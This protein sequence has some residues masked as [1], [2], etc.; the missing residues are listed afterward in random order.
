MFEDDEEL[1]KLAWPIFMKGIEE[2]R[3]YK[4]VYYAG[5]TFCYIL[6]YK[7]ALYQ[8]TGA[9]DFYRISFNRNYT[10]D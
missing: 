7:G 1:F 10:R 2:G 5:H 8:W 6:F 4:K 3:I 9:D